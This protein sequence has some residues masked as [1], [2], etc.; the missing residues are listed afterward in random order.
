[1]LLASEYIL[2]GTTLV[3]GVTAG[4]VALR[5]GVNAQMTDTANAIRSIDPSFSIKGCKSGKGNAGTAGSSFTR[6]APVLMTYNPDN[7]QAA[8]QN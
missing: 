4:M 6:Q 8:A 5:D 7:G 1:M 2:A 3:M